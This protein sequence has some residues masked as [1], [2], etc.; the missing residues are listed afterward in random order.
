MLHSDF[1]CNIYIIF[2][3]LLE[4]YSLYVLFRMVSISIYMCKMFFFHEHRDKIFE[5]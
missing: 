1:F 5:I 3:E 2:R 4:I